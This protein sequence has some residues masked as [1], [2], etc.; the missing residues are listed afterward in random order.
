[1]A[2]IGLARAYSPVEVDLSPNGSGSLLY[3]TVDIVRSGARKA[4]DFEIKLETATDPDE[5]VKA[6]AELLDLKLVPKAPNRKKA[7]T[8]IKEQWKADQ[9]SIPALEKFLDALGEEDNRPT[10]AA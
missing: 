6:V 8:V 2:R 4:A 9:L 5:Y 10:P 3:E 7:S 1:M